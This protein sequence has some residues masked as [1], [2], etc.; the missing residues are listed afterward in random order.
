M[1]R[2]GLFLFALALSA[3]ALAGGSPGVKA[4][5][6][7]VRPLCSLSPGCCRTVD[8]T[9]WCLARA[10]GSPQCL[11]GCCFCESP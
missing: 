11:N 8:C 4:A 5:A 10:L 7:C 3:A 9:A 1:K 6:P 2:I